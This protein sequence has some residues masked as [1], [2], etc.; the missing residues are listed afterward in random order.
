MFNWLRR[1]RKRLALTR[2]GLWV[3]AAAFILAIVAGTAFH[4]YSLHSEMLRAGSARATLLARVIEDHATRTFATLDGT[5]AL[6][7]ETSREPSSRG[8]LAA[9]IS[10]ALRYAPYIR[11]LHV[12]DQQGR[13]LSSSQLHLKGMTLDLADLAT[14]G[15]PGQLQ[16]DTVRDG[17]DWTDRQPRPG[18]SFIPVSRRILDE[19][20]HPIYVLAALNPDYFTNQYQLVLNSADDRAT[21]Y[22]YSGRALV[23]TFPERD[24]PALNPAAFSQLDRLEFGSYQ[25]D[26]Y[27]GAYRVSRH[28]PLVAVVAVSQDQVIGLWWQHVRIAGLMALAGS[29]LMIVLTLLLIRGQ[30]A[31]EH[32]QHELQQALTSLAESDKRWNFAIQGSGDGIWDWDIV[33]SHID[34]TPSWA[35]RIGMQ[36]GT[37]SSDLHEWEQHILPEDRGF[38]RQA[39]QSHLR[40][41]TTSFQCEYRVICSDQ[42]VL[43]LLDRGQVVTRDEQGKPLRMIGTHSDLTWRHR[44][45]QL[46]DEFVATVSHELRTPLTAI[47]GSMGLVAAGVA[48]PLSEQGRTM[49]DVAIR[50][51]D[52]LLLLINDLLDIEKIE[53]GRVDFVFDQHP[54]VPI[55]CAALES[56]HGYAE[57]LN[58]NYQWMGGPLEAIVRV[59]AH[60]LTQVLSN[61]LSNAAK[62]SPP[63]GTVEIGAEVVGRLVRVFVRDHGPGIP[64]H[65]R[66]KIFEKFSQADGSASRTKGGTGLG[67]AISRKII[68][69]MG[70]QIGFYTELGAGTEFYFVL[71][72]V[73]S[74][75]RTAVKQSS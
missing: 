24:I 60:R 72:L 73:E 23:S 39:F 25:G 3:V 10:N 46:K 58:V 32:F 5:L 35:A 20:G 49:I 28:F 71:P 53:A 36:T 44:L 18:W 57:R 9:V 50:N 27:L 22:L 29:S 15:I 38:V 54:I 12:V 26:R 70:G 56:N 6:V 51:A 8:E 17:R 16:I 64:E 65:F 1:C 45:D 55:I 42:S 30:R 75:V 31:R 11:N 67:L 52:R 40:G 4:L 37:V 47:R 63:D 61:L 34:Y 2:L 19:D 14:R 7:S 33:R 66:E 13:V 43:W 21:L 69:R 62:F 41:E 48:G 59:D 68:E 74:A